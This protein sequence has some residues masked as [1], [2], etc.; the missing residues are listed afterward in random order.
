[1]IYLSSIWIFV[2]QHHMADEWRIGID[3][4]TKVNLVT[5]GLFRVSRNPIFLGVIFTFLGLFLILPNI[6]TAIIL[7]VGTIAIQIQVRLEEEFLLNELGENYLY[8]KSKTR[9]W[10]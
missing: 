4:K 9:R 8:Y 1:M 10:V 7:F 3:S 5:K 2:A 6:L